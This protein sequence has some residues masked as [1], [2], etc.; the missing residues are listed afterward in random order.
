[1]VGNEDGNASWSGAFAPTIIANIY[2]QLLLLIR[3]VRPTLG[4]GKW[5]AA[6]WWSCATPTTRSWGFG[7]FLGFAHSCTQHLHNN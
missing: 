2:L 6:Q 4:D 1:M 7:N 3:P 5:P